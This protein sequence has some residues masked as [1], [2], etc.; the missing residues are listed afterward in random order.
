MIG[1]TLEL[2]WRLGQASLEAADDLLFD[3]LE[4]IGEEGSL[5]AAARRVRVSYRHAWGQLQLWEQRLGQPLAILS[6][7]RGASLTALG[8]RLIW[9]RRVAQA[10]L[11]PMLESLAAELA[12]DLSAALERQPQ[13]ALRIFASHGLAVGLLRD[14][15]YEQSPGCVELQYHGSLDAL[16]ALAGNRCDI[17]G[18]HLPEGEMAGAVAERYRAWLRPALHRLIHVVQRQQGLMIAS[19]NPKGIRGIADLARPGIRF[20]NR[21]A[22]SGTRLLFDALLLREG[23]DGDRVQGY[24]QEEFTHLAVAAMVASGAADAGFGLQ[25]AAHRFGLDFIPAARERY[26][27]ALKRERL[28]EPLIARLVD[29][30]RGKAFRSRLA[31]LPGYEADQAG[32]LVEVDALL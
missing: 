4:G 25:A 26:L 29:I 5:Q 2:D 31:A 18:F 22:G 1:V 6:R 23:L 24:G 27:L 21:Q 32:T 7:G 20:V 3:L 30:L 9:T 10:R 19:G 16:R 17:A 8:E 11:G 14:L 15:L 28:Q 13:P 12:R